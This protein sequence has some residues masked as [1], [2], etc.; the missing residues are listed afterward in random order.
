MKYIIEENL[1]YFEF[2]GGAKERKEFLSY[3]DFCVIDDQLEEIFGEIPTDTQIND[4]FWFD[5]DY[6]AELLG[7]EDW[8]ELERTK[9]NG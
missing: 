9:D 7:F 2:W 3:E 1:A 4:L 8:E 5:N 6:I